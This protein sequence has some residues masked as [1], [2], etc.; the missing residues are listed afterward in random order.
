MA[1]HVPSVLCLLHRGL[2]PEKQTPLGEEKLLDSWKQHVLRALKSDVAESCAHPHIGMTNFDE[3]TSTRWVLQPEEKHRGEPRHLDVRVVRDMRE[4]LWYAA[5]LIL[6]WKQSKSKLIS[7]DL[8]LW[9]NVF[10]PQTQPVVLW[11]LA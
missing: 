6:R 1:C 2:P 3:F 4:L 8:I 9:P 11:D 7:A 5:I 10:S